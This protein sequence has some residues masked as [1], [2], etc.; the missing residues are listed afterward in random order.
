[1]EG[2]RKQLAIVS[3]VDNFL[4]FFS[5]ACRAQNVNP[6]VAL[7]YNISPQEGFLGIL[8]F[9]FLDGFGK[10][11]ALF[12]VSSQNIETTDVK[13]I[14]NKMRVVATEG[15]KLEAILTGSDIF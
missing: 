12:L 7:K 6:V 11:P 8:D 9:D 3:V 2:D 4:K 10:V 13:E 15:D 14:R 5:P 1:L